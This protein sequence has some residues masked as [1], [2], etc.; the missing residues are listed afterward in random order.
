[1]SSVGSVNTYSQISSRSAYAEE[2]SGT[3]TTDD[4]YELLAAQLK[5]QDADNPMDTAEMMNQMVQTQ[6]IE[7]ITQMTTTNLMQYTMSMM[8]KELTMADIDE[9]TGV[10]NGQTTTGEI[11]GIIFGDDPILFIGEQDYRL[12]QIMSVGTIPEPPEIEVEVED[13]EDDIVDGTD[14]VGGTEGTDSTDGTAGTDGTTESGDTTSADTPAT[15]EAGEAGDTTTSG[16]TGST[17]TGATD[18][19]SDIPQTSDVTD[20]SDSTNGDEAQP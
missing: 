12:S 8:G 10:F 17:D 14:S 4:F 9:A 3:L 2:P 13:E 1:M 15:G 5:Y 20:A 11:T 6:M 19:S 18:S 16:T 7:A